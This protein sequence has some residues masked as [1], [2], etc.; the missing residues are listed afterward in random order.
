MGCIESSA[1]KGE[2]SGGGGGGGG[3]GH[4]GDGAGDALPTSQPKTVD[5]RLPFDNYRQLF[6][7]KNSWKA[8]SRSMENTAKDCLLRSGREADAVAAAADPRNVCAL[9]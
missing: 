9:L 5:G 7:L 8:V 2:R 6:N 1:D 3:G 4:P